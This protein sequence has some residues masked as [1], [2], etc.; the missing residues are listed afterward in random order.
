MLRGMPSISYSRTLVP[1]AVNNLLTVHPINTEGPVMTRQNL[2]HLRLYINPVT[3]LYVHRF[4]E[5]FSILTPQLD[6]VDMRRR[7]RSILI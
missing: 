6:L 2:H 7:I 1:V 5:L 3:C 4:F